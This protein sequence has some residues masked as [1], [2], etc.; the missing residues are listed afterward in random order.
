LTTIALIVLPALAG[1]PRHYRRGA[2]QRAPEMTNAFRLQLGLYM[3]EADSRFWMGQPES[4]FETFTG[5]E[6]DLEGGVIGAG[7]QFSLNRNVSVLTTL[8]H[9]KGEIESQ[10]YRA[11]AEDPFLLG[12]EHDS[13]L[14]LTPLT[15]AL[16]FHPAGRHYAISPYIGAGGGFYWWRFTEEGEFVDFGDPA[17]PADD[18]IFS[19]NFETDGAALGYFLV[20]GLEFPVRPSWSLFVEGR[21]HEVDD[22]PSGDYD[23]FPTIDLSGTE[24]TLGAAWRF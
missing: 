24:V 1:P 22:E 3:P 16:V 23:G 11:A 12:V 13:T 18:T 2:P 6:E 7:Y 14:R 20:G 15:V 9:Y 21:W 10:A 5:S 4:I 19:A 8:S 17:D